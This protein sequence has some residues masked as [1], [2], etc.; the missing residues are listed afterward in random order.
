MAS[1]YQPGI[2]SGILA[3]A[4]G[5]SIAPDADPASE[6]A[7]HHRLDLAKS[8][9]RS[10]ERLAAERLLAELALQPGAPAEASRL[11]HKIY[12]GLGRSDDAL[13]A[14]RRTVE[15]EPDDQASSFKLLAMLADRI[16]ALG[17]GAPSAEADRI[18]AEA[19]GLRLEGPA[20]ERQQTA[21]EAFARIRA[22]LLA[23]EEQDCAR[24]QAWRRD[25]LSRANA[26]MRDGARAEAA[27][28][29]AELAL[30][31]EAPAQVFR[32]RHKIFRG[33]GRE[34]EAFAAMRRALELEPE[35]QSGGLKLL[36]M[37]T[38][39]VRALG[40][41]APSGEVDRIIAEAADLRLDG[42]ASRRQQETLE[43]LARIRGKL[44]AEEQQESLQRQAAQRERVKAASALMRSGQGPAAE[45]LLQEVTAA[46]DAPASAFSVLAML[47]RARDRFDE[48][49]MSIRRA[50]E[51]EPDDPTYP[52]ILAALL[53]NRASE[54]RG[55]DDVD[56]EVR[57][58][59]EAAALAPDWEAI[60]SRLADATRRL[61]GARLHQ[62]QDLMAKGENE[63]AEAVLAEVAADPQAPAVAL[64]LHARVLQ[65][66]GRF[67]EALAAAQRARALDEAEHPLAL[68]QSKED[69]LAGFL[70]RTRAPYGA[71]T[72]ITACSRLI[73]LGLFDE[74]EPPLAELVHDAQVAGE[75]R[76]LLAICRQL[77]RWGVVGK[78]ERYASSDPDG[79]APVG[80]DETEVVIARRPG[81]RKVIFVFTGKAKQLWV[82]IHVLH[83][84]LP[85][86]DCHVVY[87]NDRNGS[88]YLDG[89]FG[90]GST[91]AEAVA[92]LRSLI[93]SLGD[94][95]VYCIGHSAAGFPAIRY[96]Y[97]LGADAVL[98]FSAM[99]DASRLETVVQGTEWKE[100][101]ER[102]PEV[103]V[104]IKVLQATSAD[105][106]RLL[107]VFGDKHEFDSFAAR[108]LD[109][110]PGVKLFPVD[111]AGHQVISETIADG[112]FRGLIDE[113]L[114]D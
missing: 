8:L 48:A 53:A 32:L 82:S 78:F 26:L 112:T 58:L 113:M 95:R 104:D 101:K 24:R 86:E 102:S 63:A 76:K 77:K 72:R 28:V 55:C 3:P 1:N 57:A 17:P 60:G 105:P 25:Q 29:L 33:L 114:G 110:L 42:P 98:A 81:A 49:I 19:A 108:R 2:E 12:R 50:V 27:E 36:A 67:E 37:L 10:G 41:G 109:G 92:A 11:L 70:A 7:S 89:V 111:Y 21:L 90:L 9:M 16:R 74:A 62:A 6:A 107:M 45:A 93:A 14:L 71:E 5:L 35:S 87:L 30:D 22:K 61:R 20:K 51:L 83:Q 65:R 59:E 73:R 23:Q 54:R 99:T 39:R 15:L 56:G 68:E 106:P 44:L 84:L 100:L 40:P 96:G 4:E 85:A 18:I 91:Y 47:L 80:L 31:P 94:P 66:L 75:A 13:D 46:P 79:S 52:G 103:A 97:D 38:E 34:D 69:K 88:C 43:E 64:T